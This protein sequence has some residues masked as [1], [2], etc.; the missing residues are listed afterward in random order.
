MGTNIRINT[1]KFISRMKE[2]AD[3]HGQNQ[4]QA[5]EYLG[6]SRRQ[7]GKYVSGEYD[8][9]M[10]ATKYAKPSAEMLMTIAEKYA[11]STDYL[12]GLSDFR[13][14]EN[15]FIGQ[16]TGLSDDSIDKL[17][18]DNQL[19]VSAQKAREQL[20]DDSVTPLA[21]AFIQST[22]LKHDGTNHTA[23]VLD[24]LLSP[25][26]EENNL[27]ELIYQFLVLPADVSINGESEIT[28]TSGNGAGT[29][30][31]ICNADLIK[32]SLLGSI[33]DRLMEYRREYLLKQ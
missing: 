12:L 19:A 8:G 15:D 14:A 20:N 1:D 22:L 31:H 18:A 2:L 25:S 4:S 30:V 29:G 10:N 3:E 32:E 27:L 7:Y 24:A 6:M 17:M 16:K 33:R 11:V 13:S 28:I 21:R 5:A 23:V 9:K 26:Q